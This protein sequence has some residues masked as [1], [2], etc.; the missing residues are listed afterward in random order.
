LVLGGKGWAERKREQAGVGGKKKGKGG[1]QRES[2]A[3]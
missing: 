2:A 1:G 3:G